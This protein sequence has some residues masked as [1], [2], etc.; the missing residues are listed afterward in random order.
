MNKAPSRQ[1]TALALGLSIALGSMALGVVTVAACGTSKP[2]QSKPA[3]SGGDD[4]KAYDSAYTLIRLWKDPDT[5]C[6][7]LYVSGGYV[8]TKRIASDGMTH[9]GCLNPHSPLAYTS[10]GR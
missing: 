7:Y 5:G 8:L 2:Q 4:L 9:R 10:E 1:K 6:E 3:A